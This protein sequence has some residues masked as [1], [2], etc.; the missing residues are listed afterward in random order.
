MPL[1]TVQDGDGEPYLAQVP[2]V[3]E[4]S[5]DSNVILNANASQVAIPAPTDPDIRSGWQL[6]NQGSGDLLVNELGA[7]AATTGPGAGSILVGPRQS[8]GTLAGCTFQVPLTQAAIHVAGPN[9]GD[10]FLVRSW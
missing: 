2:G 4:V 3:E 8:V 1:R 7:A 9:A 10:P 5:D 6:Q